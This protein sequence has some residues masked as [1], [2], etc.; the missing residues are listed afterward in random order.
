MIRMN[1]LKCFAEQIHDTIM[2]DEMANTYKLSNVT[3]E[4]F[5]DRV[6]EV[7]FESLASEKESKI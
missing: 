3:Q 1:E 6:I 4:F 7:I 5:K 2:K